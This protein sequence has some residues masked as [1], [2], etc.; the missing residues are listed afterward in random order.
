MGMYKVPDIY[1]GKNGSLS[2]IGEYGLCTQAVLSLMQDI[3]NRCHKVLMNNY[4]LSMFLF[5]TLYDKTAQACAMLGLLL[6]TLISAPNTVKL[7]VY[8]RF[9]TYCCQVDLYGD[10]T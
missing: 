9:L 4:Y 3:E 1:T 8:C 6:N 2:G 5:L 10:S 7:K